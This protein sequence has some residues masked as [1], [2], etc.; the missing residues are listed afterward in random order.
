MPAY[1]WLGATPAVEWHEGIPA[2]D[3]SA[4]EVKALDDD[5]QKTVAGSHL[6]EVVKPEPAAKKAEGK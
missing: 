2:R 1:R 4:D 3:L 5:Q 6:Y